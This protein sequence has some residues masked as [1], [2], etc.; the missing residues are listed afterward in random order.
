MLNVMN[1]CRV[2]VIYMLGHLQFICCLKEDWSMTLVPQLISCVLTSVYFFIFLP[3]KK[4]TMPSGF[5]IDTGKNIS[6]LLV[7]S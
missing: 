1:I 2:F 6:R 5:L 4:R 3:V 7:M